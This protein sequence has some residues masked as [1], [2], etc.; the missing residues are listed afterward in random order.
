MKIKF[1]QAGNLHEN[2]TLTYAEFVKEFGFNESR[3][4]KLK[5]LIIFLKILN[6]LGCTT[7]YIAGSFVTKKEFPNDIDLCVD[8]TGIDYV[9]LKKQYPE[10]LE[11]KGIDKIIKEHKIHFA[12]FFD[13]GSTEYLDWFRKDRDDNQRGLIKINLNDINNYDQE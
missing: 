1:N 13:F 3:I 7:V 2:H 10:F 11:Q 4:G 12:L 8:I 6:S 9:K 5:R